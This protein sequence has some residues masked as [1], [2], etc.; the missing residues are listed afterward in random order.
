MGR[1]LTKG[2]NDDNIVKGKINGWEDW[3]ITYPYFIELYNIEVIEGPAKNGISLLEMYRI[4]KSDFYPSSYGLNYPFEKIRTY[5]Y[6]K[7]KIRITKFADEY[8]NKELEK[9]FFVHGK[10]VI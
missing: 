10:I 8:L 6:Q 7:D 1:A 9:K 3:M 2:F 4:L 5:H